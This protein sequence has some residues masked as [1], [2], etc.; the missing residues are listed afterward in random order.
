MTTS[1]PDYN[2]VTLTEAN[3]TFF[4][5]ITEVSGYIFL[6]R[7]PSLS[8]LTFPHLRLIRGRNLIA[9]TSLELG[10]GTVT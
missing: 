10:I 1:F 7:I 9:G 4:N 8:L 5:E 3:L 2:T 6:Q